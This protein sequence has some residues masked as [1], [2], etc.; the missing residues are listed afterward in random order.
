MI[1]DNKQDR[2]PNDG[3][4]TT[5]VWDYMKYY[6]D[7]EKNREG[8]L[9]IVTGFFSVT[10]LE[11][12]GKHFSPNNE[13]RMVLAQMVADDQFQDHILDLLNDDCGIEN[14]L[15]L[16]D[17]A[18]NA[19]EFLR[20]DKVHVKAIINAFCH[21]KLYLFKDNHDPAHNYYVQG[22]SNLTYAGLGYTPSSNV[23]LNLAD[24]GNSDTYRSLRSWF[25]EQWTSVAKEKMP[26]DREKP[27]GAQI[28]VKQYFIQEIE[29]IFRKYTPEEIYYK[30]LFELFNSDLDLDGGIEHRQDMQLLQTSVIW[31]T[32]FNYQQKGVISLIKMLRKYNGAILADA[33]GLGK[34][35]SALAVIKYFQTQNYLTVL[36]CPKKLEQNWDQYLRRRNSRF[37]KDEFDYIVR[38]HT[39]MQNDRME[40]RYTDAK[41]SY[42]QTRKKILVVIDESH[43]LRNEKSGRYQELMA[44]LIQN[45]EGQEN[46]DVK[47]LMLSATPINT[48]L[49]DV[50]GQFNLIG[51]GKDDAFDN[52]DFGVESL[53]NLFK[54]AQTKYTQW[55]NNPDRTIGGFIATLPPKFFNLT[56]KLIVARTRK[57]IE[58]TLGEDL[59]FPDKEKPVNIYQ[60]VEHLGKLQTTEEIYQKFDELSLTAYQPSLYLE[61]NKKKAR[62]GAAKDWDDNVNRERFLVKMMGVLFMKRLESSW[63]SCMT[64]VKKVL[65]VHESTLKLALEFKEKGGNGAI[66]T[67]GGEG[68][69]DFDDEEI[70]DLMDEAYSLRKGTIK[71]SDMQN[72]GGFIRNLQMDVNKLKEIY[73]NFEAFAA[74]YEAG[75][76]KDLKLEELVRILNEKKKTKNKKVVIF[77]AFADTAQ[78]IFDE[79]KKRGFSRMASASGQNVF[80]TGTHSTKNFTAVLESFA[81]YSKLYKEKDWSGMYAD[82]RLDRAKYYN[83]EK[84][85]WNVS[86]EKWLEL[87]AQYD[88]KTLEQVNDG[89]DILI[90]T[91]CL[92]EGQNLQDADTQVNFDIHWNPVRL[93]Q[94]FGRID[95]IGSPNK[96]IRCVN[97]WPAK[98]FEDYLH[99]ETRIQNR[100]SLMK[101][102]DT[103]TQELD[104]KFK[105]MVEDNPLQDK[106]ADRLLEELQNN[107]ISDIESP[108]TLSLKD[109]S[110]ETYRQDLLDF[111]DKNRD[112][113]RRMPNGI[114][115]GFRFDDTLFE[116]IPE[117]L[118]AVVGYP[119]RKQGC[120]KPY[121]ELYLMCQP[122]DTHL[123]ATYQ[124][125]NR[126]EILEFLRTNKNQERYVPDWIESN[127]N[128]RISKLSGILK[129]WMKSKVPQQATSIILDIAKSHKAGGLFANPKKKDTKSKLLEEKFKI[130]NFDLIVWEYVS[131]K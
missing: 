83:D 81:P 75:K 54:D 10:G 12:L 128:E 28:D 20:R 107:S 108:K 24:T 39:D 21:A 66:S 68:N 88:T 129:E 22:S 2:D 131:K 52:D 102:V 30:I 116:K 67:G 41:L 46:R 77:T 85:R 45:N 114:F 113:F 93:I 89:I 1:I 3:I 73:K 19:L 119:R 118:V 38:F 90:A 87:I 117:S 59:G 4:N 74:D 50:K 47:V 36:L 15:H 58:K 18:K 95:R 115:S 62:K 48:G 126:A 51:H 53:T 26:E 99:L 7:P 86:Y 32:L 91:D 33:V 111:L 80:T 79:L 55:C 60:G 96:V 25:E 103:E 104:E 92:S 105:K 130:E 76:E 125:L 71:L 82:A 122:V 120:N 69:A 63:Y 14:A 109:F 123:P 11:L 70:D 57:L 124:E 43:N 101:L 23:E 13:Y 110:F 64:T 78:F 31:N 6:T 44:K 94:R 97:F 17:A 37:E 16:S 27:K 127:D 40:E 106:N 49:N 100:M 35:F 9:D 65:D 84:Q 5:T 72:L 112:V 8:V 34:T 98:S 121:T 42:L 61:V 29:K 56:D